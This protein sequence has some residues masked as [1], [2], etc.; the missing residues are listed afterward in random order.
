MPRARGSSKITMTPLLASMINNAKAGDSYALKV[1]RLIN[2]IMYDTAVAARSWISVYPPEPPA[3]SVRTKDG[4]RKGV[5]KSYWQRGVGWVSFGKDGT[6]KITIPSEV[7]FTKWVIMV[8]DNKY[9]LYNT[10]SYSHLVHLSKTQKMYHLKRGWRN[11]VGL[12]DHLKTYFRGRYN[13][14]LLPLVRSM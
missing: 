8:Q 1:Q 13:R 10:A 2:D 6:R 9:Y 14:K 7:M 12:F 11:E 4:K 5:R 3:A